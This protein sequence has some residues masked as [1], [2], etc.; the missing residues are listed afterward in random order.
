MSNISELITDIEYRIDEL[1]RDDMIHQSSKAKLI[2]E[3]KRFLVRC[4][5]LLLDGINTK[6]ENCNGKGYH[7]EGEY[8]NECSICTGSG[9][10]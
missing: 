10:V 7:D 3:N 8:K 4:Q 6:C 5:K 9:Q 2:K 1:E